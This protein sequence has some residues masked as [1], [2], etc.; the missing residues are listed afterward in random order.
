MASDQI[1]N[2]PESQ[3]PT[4]NSQAAASQQ[5]TTTKQSQPALKK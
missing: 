3:Q 2:Q 1:A 5:P 4:A